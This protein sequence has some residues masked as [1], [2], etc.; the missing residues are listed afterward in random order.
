V[1]AAATPLLRAGLVVPLLFGLA[2]GGCER[3]SATWAMRDAD[4]ARG[5][6]LMQRY[7]CGACHTIPGVESARGQVGPLLSQFA[8]RAYIAG[9]LRNDP[10]D[11][12][13][14]LR[15]PQSVVPGN[16]MPDTGLGA[17]DARD[18]AA[19]LYTLH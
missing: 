8:R 15:A 16:A 12:V 14:W 13:R 9:V 17:R 10:D 3:D 19:Y 4:P 6:A 11:L 7:G 1:A 2:V 18:I 5:P